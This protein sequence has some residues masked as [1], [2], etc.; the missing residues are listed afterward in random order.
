MSNE[1]GNFG[2]DAGTSLI[3]NT[4]KWGQSKSW[5]G[6]LILA[7][8]RLKKSYGWTPGVFGP[9]PHPPIDSAFE[10]TYRGMVEEIHAH[11]ETRAVVPPGAIVEVNVP[12]FVALS[13]FEHGSFIERGLGGAQA[14]WVDRDGRYFLFEFDFLYEGSLPTVGYAAGRG[15]STA[16][17][18]SWANLLIPLTVAVVRDF[19]IVEERERVLGFPRMKRV[20]GMRSK[21]KRVIYL[22]RLR[23]VGGRTDSAATAM[24]YD[25]RMAHFRR[26]HY[27]KLPPDHRASTVQIA[28]A[29][30]HGRSPPDGYTWVRGAEVGGE[31]VTKLYRSRSLALTLFE[32]IPDAHGK[33]L[34]GL[35]WFEFERHCEK[36]L[37]ARGW[38]IIKKSVARG[39]DQ[40]IDILAMRRKQMDD[41]EEVVVQC[42][43]WENTIGPSVVREL[44]GTRT[45][46]KASGALL[47]ASSAFTSAA[48]KTAQEL[49]IDLET[50]R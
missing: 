30:E 50:V 43:H 45:L 17:E 35:S 38:I 42:K 39:G 4:E 26:D 21:D 40:G 33:A 6:Q 20:T 15:M 22:P 18:V 12:P 46:R 44:E 3:F 41:W 8:G 27:R 34:P 29:R 13:L 9:C 31:E 47:M 28:M 23:Y 37:A 19:W 49:G 25:H 32:G 10:A 11:A 16:D 14:A 1:R 48:I 7:F 5:N 2:P 36:M 24:S